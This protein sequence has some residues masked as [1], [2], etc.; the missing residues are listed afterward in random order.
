MARKKK[1]SQ[2][3][4]EPTNQDTDQTN[5]NITE[6]VSAPQEAPVPNPDQAE[7]LDS[8]HTSDVAAD[9]P[10]PDDLL[11][12]VRR[13]L[14]EDEAAHESQKQSKWWKRIG[15][16]G[17]KQEA[18]T[19]EP[20]V[21]D[22]IELP[23]RRETSATMEEL[24]AE[25]E[26]KE[27]EEY[28]DEIDELIELLD[29]DTAPA[30]AKPPKVEEAPA[31]P[32]KP[33]DLAQ[34][35]K[36]AFQAKAESAGA[37]TLSEVRS[38]ALEG[39]EEV[40]VEVDSKPADPLEERVQA[41]EN[42]FKPY[43][44]YIFFA[45]AFLGIVA[46]GV[47]LAITVSAIQRMRPA[48][49][50][51]PVSDLPYPTSV[52]LPGGWAFDLGRGRLTDGAWNPQGAEWL[53]GTEVCRWVSLPWSRQLEAVV[54]TLNADDQVELVMSNSDRLVYKVDS[55]RQIS[56][57]EMQSLDTNSPCLLIILTEDETDKHW[58]L[59]ALP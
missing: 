38:I 7:T 42:A 2:E 37:E 13:A 31:E 19:E 32:E 20:N 43:R 11:E 1:K 28:L 15:I 54:R 16:G 10:S 50:A 36:Q 25:L 52:S 33:V 4:N 46:A 3:P 47:A 48:P 58:V 17:G 5:E 44:R 45:I 26:S 21:V 22:E 29:D 57:E 35:K 59:T 39:D 40:F 55:I 51:M 23:T 34:L 27:S 8:S 24:K 41:V 6:P 14:I 49:T 53:E 18:P 9:A 30:A 56:P 12:D